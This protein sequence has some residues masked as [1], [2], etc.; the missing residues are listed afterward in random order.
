MKLKLLHYYQFLKKAYLGE[1]REY[2]FTLIELLLSLAIMSI[3]FLSFHSLLE[4]TL[5]TYKMGDEMDELLTSGQ[6]AMEYIKKE[7]RQ[8]EEIISIDKMGNLKYKYPKNIGFVIMRYYPNATEKY[9]YSTYYLKNNNIYRI[10][11]NKIT[12]GY[13]TFSGK[14]G[15]NIVAQYVVSMEGTNINYENKILDLNFILKKESGREMN[16]KSKV[17]IRCPIIH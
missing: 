10:A 3:V 7:I 17:F 9:N 4:F 12:D 11:E 16:F 5:A 6:Y 1:N 14:D 13:P 8:A 2:G 15:H